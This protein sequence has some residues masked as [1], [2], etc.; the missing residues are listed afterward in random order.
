L[1]SI[2]RALYYLSDFIGAPF[3]LLFDG[4]SRA[5]ERIPATA[6]GRIRAVEQ[7]RACVRLQVGYGR[8]DYG[9]A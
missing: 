4:H 3:F 7:G 2:N 1:Q 5:L 8:S 6:C 9:S